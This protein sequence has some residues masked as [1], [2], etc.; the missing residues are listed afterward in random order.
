M[1][2]IWQWVA[3]QLGRHLWESVTVQ[4]RWE[5]PLF[6]CSGPSHLA[7]HLSRQSSGL[8]MWTVCGLCL[9][10][11]KW[12]RSACIPTHTCHH[13]TICTITARS[14]VVHAHKSLSSER[15][16]TDICCLSFSLSHPC[17]PM[18]EPSS[19]RRMVEGRAAKDAPHSADPHPQDDQEPQPLAQPPP[20][21]RPEAGTPQGK[22]KL[23]P[24]STPYLMRFWVG[25][26]CLRHAAG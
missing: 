11:H 16:S 3:N 24:H 15:S 10:C 8:A 2:S 5:R 13:S 1:C 22:W 20:E 26:V 14:Q 9:Y 19:K 4:H 17:T 18:E 12:P 7:V 21:P 23:L 6:V 25:V